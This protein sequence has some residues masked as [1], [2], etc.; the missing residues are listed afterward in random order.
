MALRVEHVARDA[1]S[2]PGTSLRTAGHFF[3]A[4]VC[5]G[6]LYSAEPAT[7]KK[8]RVSVVLID[9]YERLQRIPVP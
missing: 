6:V 4:S 3:L 1:E 2:V 9:V 7:G 8:D 5:R